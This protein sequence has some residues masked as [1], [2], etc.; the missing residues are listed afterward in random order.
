MASTGENAV[1]YLQNH[2]IPD[3]LRS[4]ML[5]VYQDADE[6]S[7]LLGGPRHRLYHPSA[8]HQQEE[9]GASDHHPG[10]D[11]EFEVLVLS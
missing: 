8:H 6:C 5:A 7:Q 4:A 2:T 9:F 11:T 10:E 1:E 3:H